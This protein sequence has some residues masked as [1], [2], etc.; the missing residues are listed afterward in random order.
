MAIEGE[1]MLACFSVSNI[2]SWLIGSQCQKESGFAIW[3]E[4]TAG[5]VVTA[6]GSLGSGSKGLLT[7]KNVQSIAS[8][9]GKSP[10]QVRAEAGRL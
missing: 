8:E 5:I 9:V 7:D 1:G 4:I 2:S 6:Y 10:A 3:T